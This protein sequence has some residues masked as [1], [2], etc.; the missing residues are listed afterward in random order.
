MSSELPCFAPA[1]LPTAVFL[2]ASYSPLLQLLLLL[3]IPLVVSGTHE[4]HVANILR[5]ACSSSGRTCTRTYT[6]CW[7]FLSPGVQTKG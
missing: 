4:Q 6:H 2:F 1:G 5:S 3:L 7:R